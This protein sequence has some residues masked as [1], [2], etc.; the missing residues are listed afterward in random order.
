MYTKVNPLRTMKINSTG[1]IK[2]R[3]EVKIGGYHELVDTKVTTS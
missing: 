3:R 2:R 1:I